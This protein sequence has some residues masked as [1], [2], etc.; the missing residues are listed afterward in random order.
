MSPNEI[1][2]TES[3]PVDGSVLA[4]LEFLETLGA[5]HREPVDTRP[6]IVQFGFSPIGEADHASG[7]KDG[8]VS[9]GRQ[10]LTNNIRALYYGMANKEQQQTSAKLLLF[11]S[12]LIAMLP[13]SRA[14]RRV[15]TL[16]QS[17]ADF[18]FHLIADHAVAFGEAVESE[19]GNLL[20]V[21]EG[22]AESTGRASV[23]NRAKLLKRLLEVM[24]KD[25]QPPA[26]PASTPQADG[27]GE[28]NGDDSD[29][30]D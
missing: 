3:G 9:E 27:N 21:I 23:E 29:S 20:R 16:A 8:P 19:T 1:R 5:V 25:Q 10:T 15:A 18:E 6:S 22:H 12:R 26:P 30:E 7:D 11:M 2:Q 24:G 17:R 28:T 14:M 4:F 13:N